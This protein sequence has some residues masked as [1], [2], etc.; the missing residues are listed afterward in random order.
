[1]AGS[2]QWSGESNIPQYWSWLT[3]QAASRDLTLCQTESLS[4]P[5][6]LIDNADC[7]IARQDKLLLQIEQ[8]LISLSQTDFHQLKRT[9]AKHLVFPLASE[10]L[11]RN[12]VD[13]P[14]WLSSLPSL[15]PLQVL[16]YGEG[17]YQQWRL[18]NKMQKTCGI[19]HWLSIKLDNQ[20]ALSFCF[21]RSYR[22]FRKSE[23]LLKAWQQLLER[24]CPSQALDFTALFAANPLVAEN[25]ELSQI[26]GNPE[27]AVQARSWLKAL[28]SGACS[29]EHGIILDV[30]NEY[31]HQYRVN[32]RKARSLLSLCKGIFVET[33]Q[34]SFAQKLTE[35]MQQTNAL[36]DLDV[37]LQDLSNYK[38]ILPAHLQ[39]QADELQ[40]RLHD[41]RK[42]ALRSVKR[43]LDSSR[44]QRERQALLEETSRLTL[45]PK[46]HKHAYQYGRK[47]LFKQLGKIFTLANRLDEQSPDNDL[48]QLRIALKKARYLAEFFQPTKTT[49]PL[50]K[51]TSWLKRL[52]QDFG[53]FNDAC[54]Q[55]LALQ[56]WLEEA[57]ADKRTSVDYHHALNLLLLNYQAQKQQYKLK[58]HQHVTKLRDPIHQSKLLA[59]M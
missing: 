30:D 23:K 54:V 28:L 47:R 38:L 20:A 11:C 56:A 52:T 9:H 25:P 35:W 37:H 26:P 50:L 5:I 6:R 27:I 3:T 43:L 33:Q 17:H 8:E 24:E 2:W 16:A 13:V 31:L 1:M 45:G 36:R 40:R 42:S 32:M 49:K 14:A 7:H 51:L 59:T 12:L 10:M 46:G 4:G 48:H 29:N 58:I 53:Q 44:Y 57:K 55:Q 41:K 39:S 34:R 22:G 15:R 19:I 21:C 18:L